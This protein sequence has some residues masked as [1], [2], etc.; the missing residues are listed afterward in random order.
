MNHPQRHA[1]VTGA[2]SGIGW[3]M[4]RELAQRGFAIIAVSNQE[5]ELHQ[6]KEELE[7]DFSVAVRTMNVNLANASS[8][9]EVFDY[10]ESN[11][12]LVEVLINNAGM[13]VIGEAVDVEYDKAADI[14]ALHVSTPALLCRLFGKK[15]ETRRHG[16]ILNVSSISAIMPY[17]TISYY[18]PSKTFLRSFSRALRTELKPHHVNVTCLMPGA[19][20]TA[21]YGSFNVNIPLAMKLGVM[22]KSEAVARIGINALF[23]ERAECIPGLLNKITVRLLPMVPHFAIEWIYRV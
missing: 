8:A 2:S 6:L 9:R 17:P 18:G 22:G 19:T 11:H 3:H 16:H 15:M 12:L 20:A 10:C 23:R 1:L 7:R 14:L 4:S 21:L 5:K 13:L